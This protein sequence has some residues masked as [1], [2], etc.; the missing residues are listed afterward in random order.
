MSRFDDQLQE[1]VT[2][3]AISD[4]EATALRDASPL[5]AER[6]EANARAAAVAAENDALRSKVATDVFSKL[7][8]PGSPDAYRLPSDVNVTDEASVATWAKS[9]NL[10]ADAGPSAEEQVALAR[11][12][13]GVAGAEAPAPP[14]L[15]EKGATLMQQI[16]SAGALQLESLRPQAEALIRESG[17]ILDS[18]E[19]GAP[20][21]IAEWGSTR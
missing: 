21:R 7:G 18:V 2:N 16:K 13:Q 6:D 12:N 10:I 17:L 11:M 20:V 4:E 3:G 9:M 1:L 5:K 19:Y 15:A 14:N 8:V